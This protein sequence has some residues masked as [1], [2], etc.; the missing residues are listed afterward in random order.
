MA[1][2]DEETSQQPP[3][4]AAPGD[5]KASK[6]DFTSTIARLEQR[7]IGA[8]KRA[9]WAGYLLVLGVYGIIGTLTYNLLR[10]DSVRYSSYLSFTK[11]ESRQTI[12]GPFARRVAHTMRLLI[13]PDNPNE[14]EKVKFVPPSESERKELR[15]ELK[16]ALADL[17]KAVQ[18]ADIGKKSEA[19]SSDIVPI[20][21]TVV[22]SVGA[23]GILILMIQISVMFIRYHLRLGEL[24]DAQADALRASAGDAALAYAL[25]QHLSPNAIE[26]GKQ[27]ATLYEKAFDAIQAVANA[28][29]AA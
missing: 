19:P 17:E 25:L 28:K 14:S 6:L 13:G 4:V 8:R 29:R 24:Y 10:N 16:E 27:P 23:I 18:I 3:I 21:S 2:D 26:V 5:L 7:A 12:E 9:R 22:F 20:V 15:S 1:D 11:A